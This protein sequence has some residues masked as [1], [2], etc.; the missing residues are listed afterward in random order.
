MVPAKEMKQ[1]TGSAIGILVTEGLPSVY[2]AEV[3]LACTDGLRWQGR[4]LDGCRCC[5]TLYADVC[6][7]TTAAGARLGCRCG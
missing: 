1:I 6:R 2:G 5:T 7:I 3:M 4:H